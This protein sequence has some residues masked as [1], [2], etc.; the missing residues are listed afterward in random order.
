MENNCLLKSAHKIFFSRIDVPNHPLLSV[1][2]LYRFFLDHPR[3][4]GLVL[5]YIALLNCFDL[6]F[7]LT[8][9]LS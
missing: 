2:L 7:L 1:L 6:H 4:E 5:D 3:I 8:F 9:I